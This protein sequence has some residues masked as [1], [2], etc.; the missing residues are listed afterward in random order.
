M[1]YIPPIQRF[2]SYPGRPEE[3]CVAAR[4]LY[5]RFSARGGG[6]AAISRRRGSTVG[7]RAAARRVLKAMSG[8]KQL[9]SR[10]HG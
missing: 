9:S 5:V 1:F 8:G 4:A 3:L 7:R 6:F 2:T 10:T